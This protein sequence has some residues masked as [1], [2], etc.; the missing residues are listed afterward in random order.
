MAVTPVSRFRCLS[1]PHTVAVEVL[2]I[3]ASYIDCHR[4]ILVYVFMYVHMFILRDICVRL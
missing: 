2:Q 3:S 4:W 1:L